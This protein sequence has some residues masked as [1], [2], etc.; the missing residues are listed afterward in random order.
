MN[1]RD[2]NEQLTDIQH[3][4]RRVRSDTSQ[5]LEAIEFQI[6][7]FKSEIWERPNWYNSRYYSDLKEIRREKNN[8][9]R[10]S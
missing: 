5:M 8:E 4:V 6:E 2:L 1:K 3:Q 10:K 9:N 7:S